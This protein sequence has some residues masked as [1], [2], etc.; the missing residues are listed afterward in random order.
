MWDW[1]NH[2][3]LQCSSNWVFN[4]KGA[5]IP[6]SDQCKT[7]DL[8]GRCISCYDGYNLIAGRCEQA[9]IEKVSDL[10]CG[11]WDWKNKKC[12]QCSS[13]WVFN[14][15]GVCVPVSDQCKT[16]DLSGSCVSCYDGYNLIGGKC[17]EAPIQKVTDLGCGL[18]DWKN[19]KCLKC[20]DNWVFNNKGV[21]TPVSDQCNTY[22]LAGNCMTCY[23]GYNLVGGKCVLA[24]L[25]N[26]PDVGCGKWDW[27]SKLCLQCSFRYVFNSLK[28]C[29]PVNDNCN[30]WNNSGDCTSCYPGYILNGGK[31]T[32]GNSLCQSIDSNGACT[33]CYTGYIL[34]NGNCVPIS[35]LANLALYYSQCCP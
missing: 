26:V 4:N 15:K 7:F 33:A 34:D 2:K 1:K 8:A 9:P 14:N 18:W 19:L 27:D 22:D 30:L 10:G 16:F 35:K 31:C 20:S 12:L 23:K 13:N 32:Q 28:K 21:C 24:P 3:C 11:L 29:V 5:C 6:V 17:V 25:D